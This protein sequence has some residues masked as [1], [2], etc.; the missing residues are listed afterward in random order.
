MTHFKTAVISAGATLLFAASVAFA[1]GALVP[2]YRAD[3][4]VAAAT[5]SLRDA[6]AHL[7]KS[8]SANSVAITR[9]RALTSCS[10]RRNCKPGRSAKDFS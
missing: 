1:Q 10:R 7:G 6:M 4:E 9:A 8:P 5:Q 3:P 2:P